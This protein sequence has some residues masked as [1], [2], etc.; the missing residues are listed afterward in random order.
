[1]YMYYVV[2]RYSDLGEGLRQVREQ[3]V[4]MFRADGE[5]Y[6]GLRDALLGQFRFIEL[7]VGGTG[8]VDDQRFDIGHVGQK[9]EYLQAIDEAE[10]FFTSSL[11]FEVKMEPAPFGKYVSYSLW[12][13]CPGNAGWLTFFTLGCVERKSRIFRVFSTWRSTRKDKVS[14]P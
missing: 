4:D 1:M 5:T 3:V 14:N 10:R 7:G 13:G 12:S 9:R 2:L 8:R 11:D 6:R